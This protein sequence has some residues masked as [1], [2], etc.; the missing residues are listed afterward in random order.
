M[1]SKKVTEIELNHQTI[2]FSGQI[3]NHTFLPV[4]SASILAYISRM[5]KSLGMLIR[6]KRHHLRL[7]TLLIYLA[8]LRTA[9]NYVTLT[10]CSD[11]SIN[12]F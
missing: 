2:R 4:F 8:A 9:I 11:R 7:L 5:Q 1:Q 10:F 12:A 6:I 3:I